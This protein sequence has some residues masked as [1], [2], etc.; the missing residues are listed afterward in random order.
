MKFNGRTQSSLEYIIIIGAGLAILAVFLAYSFIYSSSYTNYQTLQSTSL[1]VQTISKEANYILTQPLGSSITFSLPLQTLGVPASFFCNNYFIFST[2]TTQSIGY[3]N[4][5]IMSIIP[6]SSGTY[7]ATAQ[8][9]NIV[10][11]T[12]A[13]I[14][15]NLPVSYINYSY[16]LNATQLSYNFSFYTLSGKRSTINTPYTVTVYTMD[17]NLLGKTTSLIAI[18]GSASGAVSISSATPQV[19]V[20]ISLSDYKIASSTCF[21]YKQMNLPQNIVVYAPLVI[22]NTQTIA[23]SSRFQQMINLSLSNF[24]KYINETA[25]YFGQNVEFFYPNGSVV[26]S[27]MEYYNATKGYAIW[28]L[29]LGSIPEHSSETLY[30]G[31]ASKNDNLF[32]ISKGVGESP[33][34]SSVY[35]EYDDGAS[36]FNYYFNGSSSTEWEIHGTSGETPSA[37][38]GSPFGPDAFYA[39]SGSG[40]YM[41]TSLFGFSS[42]NNYIVEYYIYTTG[43][44]DTFFTVS[45]SGTGVMSRLDSRGGGNYIGLAKTASWTSWYCPESGV[46]ALA[47]T[48][49]LQSE[50]ITAN[51]NGISSY[52]GSGSNNINNL[53]TV[54]NANST[55][56]TDGCGGGTETFSENG[57][58]IGL[59]G[60]GLGSSYITYW[61]GIITR[62]YP[63]NGVM[64]SVIFGTAV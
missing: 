42:T 4:S 48:W 60:D 51:G 18:N 53:G 49:Y 61:N 39:N 30:V 2:N 1:S 37:P 56:Y 28:W 17:K 44:G 47:D 6:L 34:L 50:V 26:P 46:T 40:D 23:T 43:L 19:I 35:G 7:Q 59:V 63:P 33:R 11:L 24:S 21:P 25:Q 36:I 57:N 3:A 27:W 10:G 20:V 62:A 14:K 52:I 31:F 29:R 32:S 12:T 45:S 13:Y 55:T 54:V 58:Y 5:N 41:N 64:P 22:N 38:A 15:F 16:A 8:V 9:S